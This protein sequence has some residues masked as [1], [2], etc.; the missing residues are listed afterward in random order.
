MNKELL[1]KVI[2]NP[3]LQEKVNFINLYMVSK[4]KSPSKTA[5]LLQYLLSV[6][7]LN[8]VFNFLFK[9]SIEE[10]DSIVIL[11]TKGNIIS[12]I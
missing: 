5:L 1:I 3:T 6:N 7:L 2:N 9:K 8:E 10:T 11:D 4:N 12:I